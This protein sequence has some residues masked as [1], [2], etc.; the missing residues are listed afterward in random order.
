MKGARNYFK[1][2]KAVLTSP[3]PPFDAQQSTDLNAPEPAPKKEPNEC[4]AAVHHDKDQQIHQQSVEAML[5][6][7]TQ[8]SRCYF[9]MLRLACS[10]T[11]T[12]VV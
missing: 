8:Y 5:T 3:S 1:F 12:M 4:E 6:K 2:Q 7:S 11:L 9:S 10:C